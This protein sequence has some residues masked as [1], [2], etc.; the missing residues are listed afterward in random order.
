MQLRRPQGSERT[1]RGIAGYECARPLGISSAGRNC[2]TEVALTTKVGIELSGAAILYDIG[3]A[4]LLRLL[5]HRYFDGKPYALRYGYRTD[6]SD[7]PQGRAEHSFVG[8]QCELCGCSAEFVA[9][10]DLPCTPRS[11]DSPL[12]A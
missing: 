5:E 6:S 8:S 7:N 11:N 12:R 3:E 9:A 10:F 2:S 4:D 1:T